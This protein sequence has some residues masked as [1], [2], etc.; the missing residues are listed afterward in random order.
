M[1]IRGLLAAG[2]RHRSLSPIAFT[3]RNTAK[4]YRL[5]QLH[6]TTAGK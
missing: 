3:A 2:L 4:R 1:N 6:E 5:M